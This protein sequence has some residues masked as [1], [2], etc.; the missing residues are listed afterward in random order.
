MRSRQY[1]PGFAISAPR[2]AQYILAINRTSSLAVLRSRTRPAEVFS[3]FAHISCTG[4]TW[5]LWHK[6]F[7]T[8]DIHSGGMGCLHVFVAHQVTVL[9]NQNFLLHDTPPFP[10]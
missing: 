6:G 5:M 7:L 1:R 4:K 8:G 2:A 10:D 9:I 3:E